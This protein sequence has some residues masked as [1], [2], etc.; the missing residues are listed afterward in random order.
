MRDDWSCVDR[1]DQWLASGGT[2]RL[3]TVADAEA[4]VELCACTGEVMDRVVTRDL[5]RLQRLLD[6]HGSE[7]P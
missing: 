5:A 6:D 4:T 3:V 7:H 2:L 1:F